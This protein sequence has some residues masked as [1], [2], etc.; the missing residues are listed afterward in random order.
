MEEP[1]SVQN[2][3]LNLALFIRPALCYHIITQA[4]F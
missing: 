4:V 2:Y 1:P 3:E